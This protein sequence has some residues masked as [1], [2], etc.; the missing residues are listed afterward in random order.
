[1]TDL[2]GS[3]PQWRGGRRHRC[4][5]NLL[6]STNK[7]G[8]CRAEARLDRC[9]ILDATVGT[10]IGKRHGGRE[11]EKHCKNPSPLSRYFLPTPN[12]Y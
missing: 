12:S 10:G 6:G 2:D 11:E 1:M 3:T 5:I 4:T 8:G 7:W 9:R